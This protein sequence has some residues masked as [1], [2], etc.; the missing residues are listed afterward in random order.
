MNL[1]SRPREFF[2]LFEPFYLIL[3]Y[4]IL[5]YRMTEI[6]GLSSQ[7]TL[8]IAFSAVILI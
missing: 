5:S 2:F 6:F 4:L 8:A 1:K 7:A 3:S